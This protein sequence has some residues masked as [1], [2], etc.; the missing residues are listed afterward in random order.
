MRLRDQITGRKL[1]LRS[2]LGREEVSLRINRTSGSLFWPFASG[3]V[4][5]CRFGRLRVRHS[6]F[7]YNA[8]PEMVG[9][10]RDT[11]GSTELR[12]RFG[13]PAWVKL[14]FV[15]WFLFLTLFTA[16]LLSTG[17]AGAEWGFLLVLPLF[18][19]L[20]PAMHVFCTRRSEEDL[21]EILE[22]LEREAQATPAP[23]AALTPP[24]PAAPSSSPASAR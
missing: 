22:F 15:M 4:G 16:G 14:F 17:L 23:D 9:R 19:I 6:P 13:M 5:G 18:L 21:D 3:V 20:P 1:T 8:R 2:P 24:T 12:I 7:E 10:V 11:L